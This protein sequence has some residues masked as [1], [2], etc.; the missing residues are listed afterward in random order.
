MGNTD[1]EY[2]A[3]LKYIVT[4]W[5]SLSTHYESDMGWVRELH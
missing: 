3:G 5:V 4:K 2:I 1:K